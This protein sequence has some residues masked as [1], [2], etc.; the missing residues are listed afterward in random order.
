MIIALRIES[1]V[2]WKVHFCVDFHGQKFDVYGFEIFVI[3]ATDKQ[4]I[5]K[6]L[7]ALETLNEH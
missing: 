3:M 2:Q 6:L 7:A 5:S 1:A 4:K